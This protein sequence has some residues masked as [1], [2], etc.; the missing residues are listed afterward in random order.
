MLKEIHLL[1][2]LSSHP[3]IV[4]YHHS[5]MEASE[6]TSFTPSI[7]SLYILMEYCSAGSLEDLIQA[8]N[9]NVQ[10]EPINKEER[11]RFFK[12]R[13]LI[14]IHLLNLTEIVSLLQ[15]ITTGL[16]FLHNKGIIHCDL[17]PENVLLSWEGPDQQI[18]IAKISD[19]GSSTSFS[20]ESWNRG[21]SELLFP[22][23]L[24]RLLTTL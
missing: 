15:D 5:W 4:T 6:S 10:I 9:G 17:K 24:D 21:K 20:T 19:F 16:A 1:E 2:L 13:K 8:R 12:L 14:P 22:D 11:I 18:P 7:P 3:N 23:S